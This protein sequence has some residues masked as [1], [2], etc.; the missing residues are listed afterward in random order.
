MHPESQIGVPLSKACKLQHMKQLAK[1][2]DLMTNMNIAHLAPFSFLSFSVF[3]FLCQSPEI[4]SNLKILNSN[5]RFKRRTS[6]E[7]NR[8]Q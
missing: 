3:F 4:C 2:A 1:I 5:A 7:P 8:I 6:Y